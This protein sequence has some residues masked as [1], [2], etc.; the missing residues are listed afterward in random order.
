[1][2][3][4]VSLSGRS[5]AGTPQIG[6]PSYNPTFIW[7]ITCL[8]TESEARQLGALAL[9]QNREYQAG[10]DGALRLIDE[11][12]YLDSEPSPHSRTLLTTLTESW[13]ASYEYGYGVFKV[14]LA[15][16]QDWRSQV[17]VWSDGSGARLLTFVI[18]EV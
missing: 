7:P 13:N 3:N 17:G 14:K 6:G 15:L 5:A 1:M 4:F 10:N 12:E 8:L 2:L 18:E 11:T 16:P 9:W